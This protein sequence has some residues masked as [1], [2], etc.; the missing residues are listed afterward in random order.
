MSN[1]HHRTRYITMFV[2]VMTA[3]ACGAT[4]S[5]HSALAPRALPTPRTGQPMIGLVE[6]GLSHSTLA[7]LRSPENNT[8]SGIHSPR[9]QGRGELRFR[10]RGIPKLEFGF[11]H[12]RGLSYQARSLDGDGPE[13]QGSASGAGVSVF[14]PA[15]LSPKVHVGLALDAM[16]FLIPY[17]DYMPCDIVGCTDPPTILDE[18]RSLKPVLGFSVAPSYDVTSFLAF[19]GS[20]TMRN[21]PTVIGYGEG[22][23]DFGNINVVGAVGA[24]LTIPKVGIRAAVQ[25]FHTVTEA[26][27]KYAPTMAVSLSIPLFR[28]PSAPKPL[29]ETKA[30]DTSEAK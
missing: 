20:L 19:F 7:E 10:L 14:Y 21:H 23:V 6:A 13:L 4:A 12:E 3:A 29:V 22:N 15:R 24:A 30:P 9:H 28:G 11:T 18:G 8:N 17:V 1:P 5:Q 16:M 25:V 27:I 2:W 26:P